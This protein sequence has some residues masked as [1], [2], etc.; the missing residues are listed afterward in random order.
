MTKV[1]AIT[2][3]IQTNGDM[4]RIIFRSL[5]C[6]LVLLS[7][8][9]AYLISS[10]TFNVLARKSLTTTVRGLTT[11]ISELELS[12]LD[13]LHTINK[14]YALSKGFVDIQASIF[15]TRTASN[16]AVR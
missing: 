2:N 16:V 8:A 13:G 3:E 10:I 5:L 15:A 1:Q 9:Y 12:Y 11:N 14:E 7:V 4:Q 6:A